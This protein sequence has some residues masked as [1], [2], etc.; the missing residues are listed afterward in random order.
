MFPYCCQPPKKFKPV[1]HVLF[2]LDGTI[3][4]TESIFQ[5]AFSALGE[6]YG[7]KF[8]K[9]MQNKI[10]GC[11]QT[12]T[13]K[14]LVE[15]MELPITPDECL[16]KFLS[17]T[18]DKLPDCEYM[19]GA[20]R[21]IRHL[22]AHGVPIAIATSSAEPE[23]TLK[24][25]K[26]MDLFELFDHIVCG[27]SDPEVKQG[28]PAPDIYLIC[29]SRFPCNPDPSKCLVFEDAYNGVLAGLAAGMQTVMIPDESVPY[30]MWQHATLRL[31]SFD[32]M[33]P[34]LFGLPPYPSD[35]SST[36]PS[37]VLNVPD[38]IGVDNTG[39]TEQIV[40]SDDFG[41]LDET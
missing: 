26:K 5:V 39:D 37:P 30:E 14:R 41:K 29:A 23:V 3:L 34:Q 13:A 7:K 25:S 16:E 9:E 27:S 35:D 17:F 19:P 40:F 15:Y 24:I 1:T 11:V 38:E 6:E 10:A 12:E 2:D 32:D 28:K 36:I 20:E 22:A 21:F 33:M 31:D 4:D 8:T 18:R